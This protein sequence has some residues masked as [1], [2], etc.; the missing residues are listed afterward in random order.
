MKDTKEVKRGRGRPK[1]SRKKAPT[2]VK[3]FRVDMSLKDFYNE[4]DNANKFMIDTIKNTPE[5]K[6]FI[7]KRAEQKDINQ[8]SLF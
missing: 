2:F 4:I 3:S 1:G 6:A 5:Y 7:A 8:P